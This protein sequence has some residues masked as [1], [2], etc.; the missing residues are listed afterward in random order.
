LSEKSIISRLLASEE[1][2]VRLKTYLRLLEHDYETAEVKKLIT[3]IKET[4]PTIA[5][6]FKYLLKDSMGK[7]FHVYTKWQGAHWLLSIL[8]DIGYPAGDATLQHCIDREMKWLL[9]PTRWENK[10]V[11]DGRRRNCASQDGN[12]LYAALLLGFYDERCDAL[13]ER[14]IQ[15]QWPDGGWNCDKKPAAIN[16]SYH[17]SLIPLRALAVYSKEHSTTKVQETINKATELFLKRKLF[18]RLSNGEVINSRWLLLHYPMYWRYDVL[19]ALKVLA[20]ADKIHDKRCT[21]ALDLLESKRLGDGGFPREDKYCQTSNPDARQYSPGDWKG[22][23]KKKM[24]GQQL[25]L[26]MF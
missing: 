23:S 5:N 15:S 13:A 24:N 17:E 22:V 1:P 25:M 20:E 14:L 21:E 18:R 2:A 6:F 26:F 3:N 10:P 12:G 16:S 4:S 9:F 19:I 7:T 8:A 11:I